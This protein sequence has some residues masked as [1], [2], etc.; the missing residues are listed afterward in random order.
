MSSVGLVKLGTL[1]LLVREE[2]VSDSPHVDWLGGRTRALEHPT[3]CVGFP[4]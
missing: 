4:R 3:Y 1:A 2:V